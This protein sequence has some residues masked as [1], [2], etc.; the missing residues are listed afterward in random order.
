VDPLITPEQV[1]EYTDFGAVKNR[2]TDKLANDITQAETELFSRCGHKFIGPEYTPLP[3]EVTL[4]LKKLAEYY[5]LINSDE[6]I[7]K[8]YTSERLG[9][10]SYTLANGTAVNR[11][12]IDLLIADYIL[13]PA[14]KRPVSFRMRAL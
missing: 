11:P 3:K 5:A 9:D 2:A 7:A 1:I 13:K 6:S 4:A 8:G 12:A 10:Y 14:P